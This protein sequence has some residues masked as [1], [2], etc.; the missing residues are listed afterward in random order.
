MAGLGVGGIAVALAAQNVLGD[1]I[2]LG[3]DKGTVEHIGI[4]TTRLRSLS[5]AQL[6]ISNKNLL[7]SRV[8]KAF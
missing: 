4:K 2:V 6:I 3:D 7:E 8:K 1:F 5:G